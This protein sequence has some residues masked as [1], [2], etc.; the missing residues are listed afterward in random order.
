M[1]KKKE[2]IDDLLEILGFKRKI[3]P[4][5]GN[6]LFRAISDCIYGTQTKNFDVRKDIISYIEKNKQ[7]FQNYVYDESFKNYI[8]R[9]KKRTTWVY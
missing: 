2:K 5:D 7:F 6:C 1:N 4:K 3:L 8:I 9:M